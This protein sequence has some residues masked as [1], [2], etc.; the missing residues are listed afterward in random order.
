MLHTIVSQTA[1][2]PPFFL[3]GIAV[4]LDCFFMFLLSQVNPTEVIKHGNCWLCRGGGDG[5]RRRKIRL[6]EVNTKCHLKK[7]TMRQ[8]FICLRPTTPYPPYKLCISVYSILI[9]T[10]KGGGG[11]GERVEPER[12]GEGQQD[13]KYWLKIP[14]WLNVRKKL[15]SVC[16][17]L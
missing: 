1:K 3:E 15:T 14:T 4:K 2:G 12:R 5:W 8:V 11:E 7:F 6:I 10:G 16:K 17:L 13:Q 9:H